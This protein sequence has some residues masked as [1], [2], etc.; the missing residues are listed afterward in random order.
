MAVIEF[1]PLNIPLERRLQ[2][3]AVVHYVFFFLIAPPLSIF[4]AIYLLWINI[5][6]G[7]WL[8][9]DRDAPI[10]GYRRMKWFQGSVIWKYFADYFPQK[11]IKTADLPSDRNY[12]IGAHPHGIMSLGTFTT[13]CTNGTGF[14]DKFPGLTPYLAT[15]PGQFL[16]PFRR[17]YI[18]LSGS[19]YCSFAN[20]C[21][22]G[23]SAFK[24]YCRKQGLLNLLNNQ[25]GLVLAI[26]LGGAEEALECRHDNYDLILRKRKGFVRLA[27]E[28]GALVPCY[29]FGENDTYNQVSNNRGTLLRKLQV[30]FRRYAGFSTPIIFG[31]GIFNYT[32]GVLP[33]RTPIHTVVGRPIN[34]KPT[35]NPTNEEVDALHETYCEELN[36]LFDENKGKYGISHDT[37]LHFI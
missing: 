31:R 10:R 6:Y 34:V 11:L 23:L 5:L 16:F 3:L 36:K 24:H 1:A 26:V 7:I 19:S 13:F 14:W 22:R 17:E 2:T 33:F 37:K 20:C 12:I 15:L 28:T 25:K 8:Y 29:M 21:N 35:P 32:F 4:L 9:Y 27:L 18:L 30:T